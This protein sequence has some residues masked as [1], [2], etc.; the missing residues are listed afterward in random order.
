MIDI[1][2]AVFWLGVNMNY[3]FSVVDR[4]HYHRL[5]SVFRPTGAVPLVTAA[6]A[7]GAGYTG[8]YISHNHNTVHFEVRE[9]PPSLAASISSQA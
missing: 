1:S 5:A 3:Y 2:P 8:A 7:A 9:E 4:D 6:I